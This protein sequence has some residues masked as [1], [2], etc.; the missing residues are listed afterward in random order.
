MKI[1]GIILARMVSSQFPG[2]PLH[3]RIKKYNLGMSK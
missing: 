1:H 2:K 3:Q